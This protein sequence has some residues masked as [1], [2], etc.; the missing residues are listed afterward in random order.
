VFCPSLRAERVSRERVRAR[1]SQGWR[2]SG[3][4]YRRILLKSR[5]RLYPFYAILGLISLSPRADIYPS[6]GRRSHP[7]LSL[8]TLHPSLRSFA[9]TCSSR[10]AFRAAGGT[11]RGCELCNRNVGVCDARSA[12]APVFSR[13][14][15]STMLPSPLPLAKYRLPGVASANA[16]RAGFA[17]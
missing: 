15:S 1:A 2:K 13:T 3:S 10:R 16:R 17:C 6:I 14:R 8:L 12:I 11:G 7:S 4:A 9:G 5:R